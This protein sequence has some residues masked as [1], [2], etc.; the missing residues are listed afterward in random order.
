M[1]A[2]GLKNTLMPKPCLSGYS[3]TEYVT[4]MQAPRIGGG[5]ARVSCCTFP[6]LG[7]RQIETP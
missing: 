3:V 5:K 1:D 4:D 6:Y 2:S 7:V